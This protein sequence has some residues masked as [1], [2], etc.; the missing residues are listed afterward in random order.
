MKAIN[1]LELVGR[2]LCAAGAA[3]RKR[4]IF[5]GPRLGGAAAP[6]YQ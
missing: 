2:S 1:H 3:T 5:A 4:V 6:P